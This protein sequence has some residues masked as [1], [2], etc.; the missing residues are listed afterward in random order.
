MESFGVPEET[1]CF[2][3][4]PALSIFGVTL[5]KALFVNSAKNATR[6]FEFM[7]IFESLK[8]R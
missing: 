8:E 1:G 2:R 5:N 6:I 3:L 4:L 7:Y